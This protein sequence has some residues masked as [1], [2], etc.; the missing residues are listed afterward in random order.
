M[1]AYSLLS[2]SLAL[3]ED[4]VF[5][6][7]G[8]APKVYFRTLINAVDTDEPNHIIAQRMANAATG[9]ISAIAELHKTIQDVLENN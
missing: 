5:V 4:F 6:H 9:P 1:R 3:F 8:V 7:I 2:R